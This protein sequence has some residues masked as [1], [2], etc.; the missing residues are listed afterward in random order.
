M[1]LMHAAQAA[2]AGRAA[3]DVTLAEALAAPARA[4]AQRAGISH[5]EL[6]RMR[7]GDP[8][9]GPDAETGRVVALAAHGLVDAADVA[10]AALR[11]AVALTVTVL[12][13]D[14]LVVEETPGE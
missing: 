6:E 4:I 14:A 13:T 5:S 3:G 9:R 2:A 8:W 1:A 12:T 10:R 7:A 11:E